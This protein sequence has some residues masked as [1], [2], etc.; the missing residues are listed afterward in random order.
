M[1]TKL[2]KQY[3]AELH[4]LFSH[5]INLSIATGEFP[6]ELKTAFAVP[7]LI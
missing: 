2:V 4:Q 1:S 7:L 3:I 5:I 6:Q